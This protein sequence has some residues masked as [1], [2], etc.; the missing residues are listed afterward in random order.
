MADGR[1]NAA[2]C[3]GVGQAGKRLPYL[4]GA[5]NA[6]HAFHAW[7]SALGYEARLVTDETEPVTMQRLRKELDGLLATAGPAPIHRLVLYFAGH[8]LI[9][10]VEEGLWL[11]SDWD[12]ELRAVAVEGLRRRLYLYGIKQIAIFADACRSLPPDVQASDLAADPV[13]GRGPVKPVTSPEVDRFTSAQDGSKTYTVPGDTPEQDRC[14]F[15]GVL[16]EGLWGT[17]PAAFSALLPNRITSQSLATYLRNEV[18]QIAGRYKLTLNPNVIPTFSNGDDIYF[19]DGPQLTPPIF[20]QWPPPDK[21]L[22]QMGPVPAT[23]DLEIKLDIRNFRADDL[24]GGGSFRFDAPFLHE[25]TDRLQKRYSARRPAKKAKPKKKAI[26]KPT[27]PG[28][29]D[30]L[31]QLSQPPDFATRSGFTIHGPAV[32]R[33]WGYPGTLAEP[34][35]EPNGWRVGSAPGSPLSLAMPLCFEFA[36]GLMFATTALPNFVGA[37]RCDDSGVSAIVYRLIYAPPSSVKSTE[38]ALAALESGALRAEAAT[39]FAVRLRQDKHVDP[40]LGVISAYLY[41]AIGDLDSIRR[42]ASYYIRSDQPVPYDIALLAQAEAE[43]REGLAWINVPA[44][45]ERKPRTEAESR[46]TW[47][48][49]A[50][51]AGSGVVG[52]L[53]PW[54]RQGWTFLEDPLD[55]G[56]ALVKPGLA[57]LRRHLQSARFA[58]FDTAGGALLTRLFG[59]TAS[60]R[61]PS[62]TVKSKASPAKL[63]TGIKTAKKGARKTQGSKRG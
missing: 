58:T 14:I 32:G 29:A 26:P 52:G 12:D 31:R 3:I 57:E 54:M 10:E 20:P 60:E 27:A 13:L 50:T 33:V 16:L 56:S 38:L 36:N 47:T 45:A 6:A 8:G 4:Q 37:V 62:A 42:M 44:I 21:V 23:T 5:V 55:A 18:P 53:W 24:S 35:G 39:D 11:L 30:L 41:D 9:R 46:H 63:P 25:D 22:V 19:G 43:W 7:A 49:A 17:K 28:L 34:Y 59:F 1:R 40:V 15:S 51:P 61:A 2:V 48:Y